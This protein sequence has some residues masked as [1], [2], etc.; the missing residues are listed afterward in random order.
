[1]RKVIAK[2][3]RPPREAIT[4]LVGEE[5]S[6]ADLAETPTTTLPVFDRAENGTN[7]I[8][9]ANLTTGNIL[10]LQQT[11][12]NRAVNRLIAPNKSAKPSPP[13]PQASSKPLIQRFMVGDDLDIQVDIANW[14]PPVPDDVENALMPVVAKPNIALQFFYSVN[15]RALVDSAAKSQAI[16][17]AVK[18]FLDNNHAL[19]VIPN[20]TEAQAAIMSLFHDIRNGRFQ[21]VPANPIPFAREVLQRTSWFEKALAN[22]AGKLSDSLNGPKLD[23][24]KAQYR[25]DTSPTAPKDIKPLNEETLR[26]KLAGN[27]IAV[28]EK[29]DSEGKETIDKPLNPTMKDKATIVQAIANEFYEPYAQTANTPFSLDQGT[30]HGWKYADKVVDLQQEIIPPETRMAYLRN[31]AGH[32][33]VGVL[34]EANFNSSREV[35]NLILEE[36]L[37]GL[38]N[39]SNITA[40]VDR[41]LRVHGRT[42][43]DK[44]V[45]LNTRLQKKGEGVEA[46]T[47]AEWD[48]IHTL[49]HELM[50]VM[51]HP[52]FDAASSKIENAQV[53]KE[54]FVELLG[55]ELYTNILRKASS[56]AQFKAQITNGLTTAELPAFPTR[57]QMGY[58]EAAQSAAAV[59]DQVG[60]KRV[61]TAFFL[62]KPE[63]VGIG[64]NI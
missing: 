1:M 57:P 42:D 2:P 41:H 22:K 15:N 9:L 32:S 31:R 38:L 25:R 63:L 34:E 47:T 37:T 35:D 36:I 62:G 12:G 60:E 43:A 5:T 61:V 51:V 24:V 59:M 53:I 7:K 8:P 29:Y 11:I 4:P 39:N 13:H 54:G 48:T 10:S 49:C 19:P 23:Y 26:R 21:T 17:A 30:V 52:R 6:P 64:D 14:S 44:V 18:I 33:E 3:T 55:F 16:F 56:N 45:H 50:H 27:L 28:L 46:D 58:G 20:G 40:M